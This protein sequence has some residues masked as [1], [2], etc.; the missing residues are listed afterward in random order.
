MKTIKLIGTIKTL[1]PLQVTIPDV[2]GMPRDANGDVYFPASSIRGWLRHA[3]TDAAV[4]LVAGTK[5]ALSVDDIY[6]AASG[7][8]T[9]RKVNL[10][11]NGSVTVGANNKIREANPM[12]S[13]FGRWQM[14][15]KL[16]V[17]NAF[18][19]NSE[20][21][22]SKTGGGARSHAFERSTQL[23][24]FVDASEVDYLQSI[25]QADAL[26]A[27]DASENK[28]TITAL[29]R[30]LK[31]ADAERKKE[32]FDEI[33]VL[34]DEITAMK[35]QRIGA[36]ESIRRPIEQFEAIGAGVSMSHRMT[37]ADPTKAEMCFL[38]WSIYAASIN[39]VLGGK[40]NAGCGEIQAE[41]EVR[42]YSFADYA[43]KVIGTVSIDDDGFHFDV[44]GI[45]YED[46]MQIGE[47][48]KNKTIDL[49]KYA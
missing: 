1:A 7:V 4:Q 38:L 30:S 16:K 49:S 39:P 15:G 35:A 46:V 21:S 32:I 43:P 37:I 17:G 48:I 40:G 3:A 13:L 34:E 23:T 8:D 36:S 11:G 12:L 2:V 28:R 26:S 47:L 25:L 42:E 19:L 5:N 27:Q 20:N 22:T 33:K 14:A 44:E 9:G 10:V 31:T 41:W 18:P 45:S 6:M 24:D 29:K